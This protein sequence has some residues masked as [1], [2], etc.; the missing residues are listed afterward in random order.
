MHQP[1]AATLK[2]PLAAAGLPSRS[3]I[4]PVLVGDSVFC[5]AASDELLHRHGIYVQPINYPAGIAGR[6]D[7]GDFDAA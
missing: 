5:E 2:R 7:Y 6:T 4:V 1:R 3:H